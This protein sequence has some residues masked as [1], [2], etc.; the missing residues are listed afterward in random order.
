[1]AAGSNED[2]ASGYMIG[3][4]RLG[5]RARSLSISPDACR[6]RQ[7]LGTDRLDIEGRGLRLDVDHSFIKQVKRH[8]TRTP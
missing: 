2:P 7:L 5:S 6:D 3:L 4:L 1:M 8:A